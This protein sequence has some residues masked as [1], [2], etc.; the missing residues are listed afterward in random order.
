MLPLE[1]AYYSILSL[2]VI[3]YTIFLS[4]LFGSSTRKK[5]VPTPMGK[6]PPTVSIVIPTYNEAEVIERKLDNI[7]ELDFPR[8]K[9]EVIVVDSASTDATSSIAKRFAEAHS[10]LTV[11]VIDQPER[12]GKAHAINEALKITK[13]E[14]FVLTDADV[15]NPSG[16]L[17]QL[18]TNFQQGGIGAASGVEIPVAEHTLSSRV[19]NGYKA[20]Y[21]AVRMAE[22]A[23][24]TPFMCESEFS[25]YRRDAMR[26]LR[27]GCMCDDIELTVG[28]RSTGLKGAYDLGVR[29]YEKEAGTPTSKLKHKLRRGMANQ[30]ALVR[31]KS[32]L[33]DSKLGNYGRIIFP[34]EFFVHLVSPILI[35]LWFGTLLTLLITS[36]IQGLFGFAIALAASVPAIA[37]LYSLTKKYD[38]AHMMELS[39]GLDLIA[40]AAAFLFF[41]AALLWSLLKLAL[42]GPSL[43]WEKISDT[44]NATTLGTKNS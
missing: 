35:V 20:M 3:A 31:T 7:A 25:A 1:I 44:R 40:G 29:F 22:N 18:I 42:K 26:P 17:S 33:F 5:V 41:Q 19:E 14:Y 23:L 28:M 34:F 2:L 32:A 30:H 8:E 15:T 36:P 13:S 12:L 37:I 21:T 9:M 38:T 11:R 16:A 10:G 4:I 24:D 27:P 43:K 6:L 39:G